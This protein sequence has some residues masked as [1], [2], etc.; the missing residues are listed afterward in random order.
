MNLIYPKLQHYCLPLRKSINSEWFPIAINSDIKI[1]ILIATR[2]GLCDV[3]FLLSAKMPESEKKK[4]AILTG[5]WKI[6]RHSAAKHENVI[7]A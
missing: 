6:K 3:T 2:S 5:L 1:V 7:C 4:Q